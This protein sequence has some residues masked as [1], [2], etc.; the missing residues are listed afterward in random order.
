MP[1]GGRYQAGVTPVTVWMTS[2]DRSI[3][4]TLVVSDTVGALRWLQL[5]LPISWPPLATRRAIDGYDPTSLPIMKNVAG[6]PAASTAA[7]ALGV[8]TGVGP[9]SK[10]MAATRW[11]V[12]ADQKT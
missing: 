12:S 1:R 11:S 10:V 5:W 2:V 3:S 4:L 7:S 8:K 6:T 9:S